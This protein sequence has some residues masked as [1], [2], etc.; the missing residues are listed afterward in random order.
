MY[1]TRTTWLQGR[2]TSP[3][4]LYPLLARTLRRNLPPALSARAPGLQYRFSYTDVATPSG[5]EGNDPMI[6]VEAIHELHLSRQAMLG[7]LAQLRGDD[8][9]EQVW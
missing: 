3:R 6:V 8:A 1:P 4:L 5:Q 7:V 2:T 9:T